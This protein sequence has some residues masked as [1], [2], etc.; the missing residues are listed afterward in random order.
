MASGRSGSC[1]ALSSMAFMALRTWL[2]LRVGLWYMV[3]LREMQCDGG[4]VD[5]GIVHR[6]D[7]GGQSRLW[8]FVR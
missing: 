5:A 3:H 6:G 2:R 4:E 8:P 1:S 7:V